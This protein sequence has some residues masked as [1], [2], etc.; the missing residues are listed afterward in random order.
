MEKTNGR[1]APDEARNTTKNIPELLA[2]AGNMEAFLAA[3][4]HGA[5]AVYLGGPAFNARMSAGNFTWEE[6]HEAIRIAHPLDVRIYLAMN[7]LLT[8]QELP[9][10][11]E[12]A[13]KAY[14][15]GIDALIVQD[16][17]LARLVR[18]RLP[19]FP[20]HLSTQGTVYN[21]SGAKSA[22]RLGFRRVV[23]ARECSIGEI[24]EVSE[25]GI[26]ET[27]VFIHGA[28]CI[29]YSGQ[30]HLSRVLGGRSA[31]KG[32]CAQP[33]RLPYTDEKGRTAYHLSPRDLCG[34]DEI[35]RLAAAGVRSLKI[36]GR[37][38]SAVYVG[39]VTGIYRK[40]LDQYRDIGTVDV[41]PEDR[42]QLLQAFSRGGFTRG[43]LDGTPEGEFFSG[44]LPKN[45][46][47]PVGQVSSLPGHAG[48]VDITASAPLSLGDGIEIHGHKI[49]GNVLT[50][51]E[52]LPGGKVR[53]GDF[54]GPI[55]PGNPIYRTS[56][57]AMGRAVQQRIQEFTARNLRA[58]PVDMDFFAGPEMPAILTIRQGE[59]ELE[60]ESLVPCESAV[61]RP[62]DR[63]T[64]LRQL[65]KTGGTP[66]RPG[67]LRATILPDTAVPLSAVNELRRRG[68]ARFAELKSRG[69]S[70]PELPALQVPAMTDTLSPME[71]PPDLTLPAVLR[72]KPDLSGAKPQERQEYPQQQ[73]Q[74]DPAQSPTVLLNSLAWIEELREE[75]AILLGGPGLNILNGS[76]ALALRELGVTPASPSYET[77][78]RDLPLMTLA[79]PIQAR[80]L[81]DRKGK[82]FRVVKA[83][84]GNSW[85]IRED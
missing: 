79:I 71:N 17:G 56:S 6:I 74:A 4:A 59:L 58:V 77:A 34:I 80:T 67:Q 39:A 20:L 72:Q 62:T 19:D 51:L 18:Q 35:P 64:V 24:A 49:S 44:N 50:Y 30:C 27:E 63:E 78:D 84:L 7:T 16:L 73:L 40:Y 1:R 66:F 28:L 69:R 31:N 81:T 41:E 29:C 32:Q 48:L 46:G 57:K 23:L 37:M 3:L 47:V 85:E 54:D 8:D 12:M 9:S 52:S 53:I 60:V 36:E 2:P 15:A 21:L 82:K 55:R 70:L 5:D 76:A 42:E 65:A 11:V 13:E 38:K 68:L 25:S 10:A 75:G 83:P 26:V 33:C 22:A 61:H 45:T 14:E 43:Y